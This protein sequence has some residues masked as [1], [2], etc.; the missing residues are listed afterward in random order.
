MV[1]MNDFDTELIPRFM[2][3]KSTN[4]GLKV[5]ISV[6]G[7]AAGDHIF[8]DMVSSSISRMVFIDSAL[9]F[10]ATYGFD[11]IDVDWEYP[12]AS[13][14]DGVA[15]DTANYVI[16]LK[17]L[18]AAC[19]TKYGVTVTLPSSYWY[20]QGFDVVGMAEYVDAF[21]FMSYDI[22]DTWDGNSPYTEAV[23]HP[24]TNLTEITDG[25]DLL[26]RNNV[27][28][29]KVYL[30]LG[31]YGRSCTLSD[32]SCTTLG[33]AFSGGGN[34]GECTQTSGIL[35]NAEI[36]PIISDNNPCLPT[37]ITND[38]GFALMK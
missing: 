37:L 11:G 27:E 8:S 32:P 20:L 31:F 21:N 38:I 19:G 9:S 17:E 10:M 18:K 15:A 12:A 2:N 5:Y 22:H 1:K 13:D 16:F 7:W 4:T 30:G 25:L 6:G 28:P 35:S 33:Y 26:W 34:P 24:H 29:S 23:V 3:L 14:R 36:Q